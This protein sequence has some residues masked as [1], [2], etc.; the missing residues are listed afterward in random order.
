MLTN[1]LS[2]GEHHPSAGPLMPQFPNAVMNGLATHGD[3][4][5]TQEIRC[6]VQRMTLMA[7]QVIPA[8]LVWMRPW[9]T[10]WPSMRMSSTS[11][12]AL[13]APLKPLYTYIACFPSVPQ[14]L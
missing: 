13:H 4:E 3:F 5:G 14:G 8:S 1:Q 9:V 7:L 6:D 2:I 10:R 11:Y 12:V